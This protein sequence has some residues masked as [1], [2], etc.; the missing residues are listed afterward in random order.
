MI[1]VL[2]FWGLPMG[3]F[4]GWYGLSYFNIHFGYVMLTRRA[5]DLVFQIYADTLGISPEILPPMIVRACVI[6]T[7]L[8][9]AILAFRRRRQIAA[10]AGRMRGRYLPAGP[11]ARSDLSRSSAP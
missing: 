7:I 8:V 10:W 5:H 11:S 1:Y 6:D 9:F 3:V 2:I 4:W